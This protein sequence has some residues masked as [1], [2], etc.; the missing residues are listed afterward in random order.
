MSPA[1]PGEADVTVSIMRSTK[2]STYV[3]AELW[4]KGQMCTE[5]T[6]IQTN[7]AKTQAHPVRLSTP[8][9]PDLPFDRLCQITGRVTEEALQTDGWQVR[10][11][12]FRNFYT[13]KPYIKFYIPPDVDIENSKHLW[14][15]T[16][17]PAVREQWVTMGSSNPITTTSMGFI[18]DC[19]MPIHNN[20]AEGVGYFISTQSITCEMRKP[21]PPGG[22][23]WIMFRAQLRECSGGKYVYDITMFDDV[24]ETIVVARGVNVLI[25]FEALHGKKKS[26]KK[27]ESK[28]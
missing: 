28:I 26:G 16:L 10:A 13:T 24:G 15:P 5:V 21:C 23:T 20:Y 14:H 19:V 7:L 6:V 25:P 4:Q 27:Q 17:G 3:R 18:L 2:K 22:W 12:D 8:I 9:M 11:F 1:S